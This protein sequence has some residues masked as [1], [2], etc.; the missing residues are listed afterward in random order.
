MLHILDSNKKINDFIQT[1]SDRNHKLY[2][3]KRSGGCQAARGIDSVEELSWGTKEG[4]Y[5]LYLHFCICDGSR[6]PKLRKIRKKLRH[7]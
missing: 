3:G 4:G 5:I 6:Q 1:L 2:R 7:F